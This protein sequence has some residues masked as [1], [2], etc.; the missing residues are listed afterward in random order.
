MGDN[1][2][3]V[4]A[5]WGRYFA[6]VPN[7]LAARALSTDARVTRAD[8]FDLGLTQP[9]PAG[10]SAADTTV[11]FRTAGLSASDFDPNS[12]S[13]YSDEWLT[14]AE[15]EA[16]SGFTLGVNYIHRNFGRVLED[17]GTLPMAAYF[18]PD[19]PGAGSVEYFITNPGPN[20]P[21]ATDLGASFEKPIRGGR[22]RAAPA[23]SDAPFQG[24]RE[25]SDADQRQPRSRTPTTPSSSAALATSRC[26]PMCS[27]CSTPAIAVQYDYYTEIAPNRPN[28][29]FGRVIEYQNP[30]QLRVG[31]RF[32]F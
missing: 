17:V 20:T 30:V 10:V 12:K 29:D 6:K 24:V 11:H 4:F 14:G 26:W 27:T 7:D 9:A 5:N 13:T 2:L 31:V 15:Y 8:Y 19:V 28:P 23:R 3:K 18:L 1:R 25:L 21:V 22:R 16:I 32:G